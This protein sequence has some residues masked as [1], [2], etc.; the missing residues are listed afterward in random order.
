VLVVV[1]SAVIAAVLLVIYMA[2]AALAAHILTKPQRHGI[3][4]EKAPTAFGVEFEEVRFEARGGRVEIA[5]WFLPSGEK[6]K[7]AV[8]LVH[9]KD[10]NRTR[11]FDRDLTDRIPG[12]FPDFAAALSR[13]GF[14]VL[15]I[16]LRGHGESGGGRFSFGRDERLDILGAVDWL[17]RRGFRPGSIGVLGVSMGAAASIGAAAVDNRITALVADSSFAELSPLVEAN[18]RTVT[19]LPDSFLPMVRWMG[20]RLFGCDIGEARPVDEI[21]SIP[22]PM[23]LIHG[24]EDTITPIQHARRLREAAGS[25]AELWE[26]A[27]DHHAGAYFVNPEAY[28]GKVADFFDRCL[29]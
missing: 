24:T 9:G 21:G 2:F 3:A 1:Y 23:L 22:R 27:T 4:R 16:D 18:W 12:E 26:V 20:K 15:M 29:A 25:T 8:V 13:R 6:R 17:E 7:K 19:H 28:L 14:A 11:E 5:G 10:A